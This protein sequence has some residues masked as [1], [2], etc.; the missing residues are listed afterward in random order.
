MNDPAIMESM[1]QKLHSE[2]DKLCE[3]AG[4]VI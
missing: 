2:T 4:P 1:K 3:V